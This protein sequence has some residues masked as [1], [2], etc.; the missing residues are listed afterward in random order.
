MIP[1]II[2]LLIDG[3]KFL[4]ACSQATLDVAHVRLNSAPRDPEAM[5]THININGC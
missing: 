3:G 2:A 4:K 5:H 1:E